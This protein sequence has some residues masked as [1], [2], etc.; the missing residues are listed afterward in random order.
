MVSLRVKILSL[1]PL[2]VLLLVISSIQWNLVCKSIHQQTLTEIEPSIPPLNSVLNQQVITQLPTLLWSFTTGMGIEEGPSTELTGMFH[3]APIIC[4][5]DND[6]KSE[7]IIGSLDYFVYALDA[8]TSAPKWQCPVNYL[9]DCWISV[10]DIKNNNSFEIVIDTYG[11]NL[12][13][14]PTLIGINGE[15]GKPTWEKEFLS[16]DLGDVVLGDLDN[17]SRLEIV[18]GCADNYVYALDGED[19]NEVWRFRAGGEITAAAVLEDIDDD[20]KLEVIIGS[21]DRHLYVLN[22]EDGSHSWNYSLDGFIETSPIIGDINSDND[23]EIVISTSEKV[24]A[25]NITQGLENREIWSVKTAS[26]TSPPCVADIDFDN[27]LDIVVSGESEIFALDG[28]TGNKIW[29]FDLSEVGFEGSIASTAS[30]GDIDNDNKLEI[31]QGCGNNLVALEAESGTLIWNLTLENV[32]SY[33]RVAT[34]P[35]LSDIDNDGTLEIIAS[36][37]YTVYGRHELKFPT[38]FAYDLANAGQRVYWNGIYG[39]TSPHNSSSNNLNSVDSDTD[40][41]SIYSEKYFGTDALQNDTDHDGMLDGWEVTFE[42]LDPLDPNDSS[43]DPDNDTLTNIQEFNNATDPTNDDTDNDNLPDNWEVEFGTNPRVE[44]AFQDPDGDGLD[45]LQECYVHKTHPLNNDTDADGLLDGFEVGYGTSPINPDYDADTMPDGWEY[46]W[47]LDPKEYNFNDDTD[48]DNLTDPEEYDLFVKYHWNLDPTDN[49]T[50]DDGI[51]DG[52]EVY[53]HTT[54]PDNNDTDSD[55]MLDGWEVNYDLNP[56]DATDASFDPD[57]DGLTNLEECEWFIENGSYLDPTDNDTDNDERSDGEEVHCSDGF[58]TDPTINDTDMDGIL[59]GVE[60][61]IHTDPTDN[62]TDD[63][64][65]L[66]GEERCF[67]CDPKYAWLNPNTLMLVFFSIITLVGISILSVVSYRFVY[68]PRRMIF[69]EWWS[70]RVLRLHHR[71]E[72]V[73]KYAGKARK[74]LKDYD[75]KK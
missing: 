61:E 38:L 59:D 68:V 29:A 24:Y 51:L 58:C 26:T 19:Q 74:L 64:G 53:N 63:D 54:I 18:V 3:G 37:Y 30:I 41:L 16:G 28:A 44:D 42:P 33:S 66:D 10:G 60:I 72:D 43:L 22:G 56:K 45:N 21:R 32:P 55:G 15:D 20:G 57:D 39:T 65:F 50:D 27:V 11:S 52:E 8:E 73:I 70:R 34:S 4:D 23:L 17:D 71:E 40:F 47:G 7:I 14:V 1:C 46:Y 67:L 2:L 13:R 6:H 36:C 25:L 5:I 62:D 75:E 31:I 12:G 35:L 48:H 69:K 9:S 49:D